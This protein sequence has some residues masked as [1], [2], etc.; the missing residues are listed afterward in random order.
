MPSADALQRKL[1]PH[2]PD[3]IG[4]ARQSI[5]HG[6]DRGEPLEVDGA[7]F[8]PALQ[9]PAASFVTLHLDETLRGCIG[10]IEARLPLAQDVARNAFLA[11]FHDSRFDPLEA[12]EFAGLDIEISVLGSPEPIAFVA[13]AELLRQLAAGRDGLIIE[14]DG[15]RAV[16]LPQVWDML[17]EPADFLRNLKAKA[18]IADVALDS[19]T[20]A[21]RFAVA[22]LTLAAEA[23]AG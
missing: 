19:A 4:L 23:S 22:R 3:L 21:H 17:P 11:A 12:H 5:R 10:T 2:V 7:G 20:V 8:A 9:A 15:R 16:F 18:G 1:A 6:L 14:R 13:E